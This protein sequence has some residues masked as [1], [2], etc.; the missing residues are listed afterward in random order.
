MKLVQ[1]KV[2]RSEITENQDR[3]RVYVLFIR[4]TKLLTKDNSSAQTNTMTRQQTN[5]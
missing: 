5:Y 3:D 1:V 2:T 4:P